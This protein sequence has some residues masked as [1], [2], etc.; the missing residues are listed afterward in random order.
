MPNHH[1]PLLTIHDYS[2]FTIDDSRLSP[3]ITKQSPL[4]ID[5]LRLTHIPN[6]HSPLLTIHDYSRFTID[7]SRLSPKIIHHCPLP[8][9][10]SRL[11]SHHKRPLHHH[12]NLHRRSRIE[13][14]KI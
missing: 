12:P 4:T 3:N 8:T 6:H 7:H 11:T 2:R 10:N 5:D 9:H 14:N 1:S 13:M